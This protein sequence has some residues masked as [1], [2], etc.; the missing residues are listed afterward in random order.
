MNNYMRIIFTFLSLFLF[1]CLA[2]GQ[3]AVAKWASTTGFGSPNVNPGIASLGSGLTTASSA[4]CGS[5]VFTAV[6][7][8]DTGDSAP[9]GASD[10]MSDGEYMEF[11]VTAAVGYSV[12]ISSISFFGFSSLSSVSF[13]LYNETTDLSSGGITVAGTCAARSI[14]ITPITITSGTTVN[15]R[16]YVWGASASTDSWG[17][18][19]V[20]FFGN[21]L[22]VEFT[23][24]TATNKG[25]TN[26]LDFTTA[27]EINNDYFTIERASNGGT[28]EPLGTI[29]G[30]GDSKADINYTYTDLNPSAGI[31]HY[32]IMQT[33]YDGKYSYSAVRS[34]RN[35][36]DGKLVISPRTTEGTLNILTDLENYDIQVYDL[37]GQEV[38]KSTNNS[39]DLEINIDNVRAGIY[40]VKVTNGYTTEVT[41]IMKI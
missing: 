8:F 39:A 23:K 29:I 24:F 15:F 9:T 11:P 17:V 38:Y 34:V 27:S 6:D 20:Q 1:T 32:R 7:I 19:S 22:P 16:L 5:N 3:G 37:S 14:S 4:G 41:K 36:L 2:T 31:N 35:T 40:F 26:I 28:F 18:G 10:A 25:T 21:V 13:G 30:A 12:T 33:D